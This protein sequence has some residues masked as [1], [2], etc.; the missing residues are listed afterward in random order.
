MTRKTQAE[1]LK[2][3]RL[4]LGHNEEA[5]HLIDWVLDVWETRQFLIRAVG[6]EYTLAIL[7]A[8]E[9][10]SADLHLH[11]LILYTPDPQNSNHYSLN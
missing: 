4:R 8:V 9:S 6:Q 3:I 11:E 1:I 5:E 2:E 7:E 10:C